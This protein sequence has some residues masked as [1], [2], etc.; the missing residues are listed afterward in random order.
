MAFPWHRAWRGQRRTRR[1][2]AAFE[3]LE[4][5]RVLDGAARPFIDLGP[6]DNVALD[7]PRV[8]VEFGDALGRSIGPDIFNSWLLDTGAN[9]V[10]AFQTAIDDMN[11]SPPAYEVEGRFE[12]IGVGGTQLFDVSAP[13]RLDFAGTSGVR[14]TLQGARIISDA[15]RDVSMFGPFGIVGMPAMT[16]RVTTLDFTPWEK[17]SEGNFLMHTEFS[18]EVPAPAGPRYSVSIDDR[19]SFSPDGHVIEGDYPP[20]WADI[21]FFTVDVLHGGRTVT[22]DFMFDTGAQVTIISS[23]V[24]FSLGLDSNLD[25]VLDSTDVGYTR[26]ETVGGV[27][28]SRDAPVFMI[29]S[30]HVPTD[31]GV[32]LVWTDLLWLV[33][34]IAPGI[35]GV[36]GFD[37]MTSGWIEATL[38]ATTAGGSGSIRQ[39]HLDFRGWETAGTGKI[40]FD[41]NP[42]L[43]AVQLPEGPGA[44]IVEPGG[45]TTVS[46]SGHQDTYTMAL[47]VRPAADV[48]VEL[49]TKP[50][51]LVAHPLGQPSATSIRFTPDDWNVPR[52]VVV[53][54]VDDATEQSLHRSGIR[55]VATSADPA[56]H[57]VG[58]P[59]VL[60]NII[61]DDYAAVM[62]LPTDLQT[63]VAEGG[64]TDTYDLVLVRAPTENVT[65]ALVPSGGQVTAV[66]ADT[67][68][69]SLTFTPATWNQPQTVRVTAVDDAVVEG[70]HRAYVSHQI[71]SGDA[72]YAEAFAI[73]E[74]VFITDNDVAVVANPPTVTVSSASV[75]GTVGET[76]AAGGTWSAPD[77]GHAVTLAASLGSV[78]QL[79]GG[80]WTW[81]HVASA[82]L[83]AEAVT[84]TATDDRGLSAQT[85]FTVTARG[86]PAS[87]VAIAGDGG[88]ALSWAAP[89]A[90]PGLLVTGYRVE[91]STDDGLT[92]STP[93]DT[94]GGATALAVTG[95]VNGTPYRFRVAA[96]DAGGTGPFSAP[97]TA[98]TPAAVPSA[99]AAPGA[100]AGDGTATVTWTAPAA[101]GSA[102]SGYRLEASGDDG[103]TWAAVSMPAGTVTSYLV[104]GLANGTAYRFRVAADNGVG[105]GPFSAPSTAVTPQGAPGSSV[106]ITATAGNGT[107][108]LAWT[109]PGD[110]GG[111]PVVDY[112]LEMSLDGGK[113]WA[114]V[115]RAPSA[116]T[117]Q[118]VAGLA[119][120][121]AYVF[122][123]AAVN[124]VGT[125]P[126]A[127]SPEAIP[128]LPAGVPTALV[129]KR[130]D[131]TATLTW[132]APVANG[133]SPIVD[134]AIERSSDGGKT[135]T[136]VDR[137]P[138]S[139]TTA[140]VAGLVNGT[141]YVFRVAAVNSVGPAA[142]TL[143]S[144]A[145]MPAAVPGPV[146]ALSA[147]RGHRQVTLTWTA[148]ASSGGLP[149]RD[150]AVEWSLD[151]GATWRAVPHA[152]SP[153]SRIVV[154]GLTNGRDYLFRVAATNT[155]GRGA[156]GE[157]AGPVTPATLP[158]APTALTVTRG[159]GRVALA[160]RAPVAD[161][162]SRI[163][164]Y[165]AESSRD[166]GKTWQAAARVTATTAVVEGLSNGTTYLFRVVARNA[167]G[168]GA[169]A[170]SAAIVPA[171][172][173]GMPADLAVTRTGTTAVVSWA[174][175]VSNGGRPIVDYR[176]QWSIDGGETWKTVVR[177]P[178]ASLRVSLA[179][180]P[181]DATLRV[182]L[183]AATV[184][185]V[186]EAAE[187]VSGPA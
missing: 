112:R 167:V 18:L 33:V 110:D 69:T 52:T 70:P 46:E 63:D 71:L 111:S 80:T 77:A 122:R 143:K 53:R 64:A 81:S 68:L 82:P 75:S 132:K 113:V 152:P 118:V 89:A 180:V 25:G 55:H 35:D 134:Y 98:V 177:K 127:V 97:S 40:H 157:I 172:I 175:P 119:N 31:Q 161:G 105:G 99:P 185:G 76:L 170:R 59:Q 138:S 58:M 145:I 141:L 92:W 139:A 96:H 155:L 137:Q 148:P 17:F 154:R 159:D 44:V 129:A 178:V 32:D 181:A 13:Y 30:V 29:D 73:P 6:S 130:G 171:T 3:P 163:D 173:P 109:A 51:Q 116:A 45:A 91:R 56:Y 166:G 2:P 169:F 39:S 135:W 101:N 144:A 57:G 66:G 8:T 83:G 85:T 121:M 43:A 131:G 38:G 136:T 160:W 93:I 108:T 128:A 1:A 149:I 37:N 54:A 74:I 176:L 147:V 11:E 125:G 90:A 14:Q 20:V 67:G 126:F 86:A 133:G 151:G 120:G 62:V 158:A 115:S 162:G 104:T 183:V 186:G 36:F 24:A 150:H 61:D 123:V 146:T 182:R 15:T 47:R 100:E 142:F 117:G 124:G 184:V 19:V 165:V 87:V 7:Q 107:V 12:E 114:A 140:T 187:A 50:T 23:A 168:A 5:R 22:G 4:S 42:D 60:V 174:A 79:A 72:Q 9:T 84:I 164:E 16:E 41:I 156:A 48:V 28:G 95:L 78:T 26:T 21:P 153:A 10:L 34:D 94:T 49:V 88:A 27:G 102:I 179:G 106:G 65:I 103:V